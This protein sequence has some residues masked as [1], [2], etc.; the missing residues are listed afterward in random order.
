MGGGYWVEDTL[1]LDPRVGGTRDFGLLALL[2]HAG[3]GRAERVVARPRAGRQGPRARAR[4][5]WPGRSRPWSARSLGPRHGR[6]GTLT[7]L[8][9]LAR[10]VGTACRMAGAARRPGTLG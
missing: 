9:V 6:P 4:R 1:G 7:A 5:G 2:F 3:C 10:L 8:T